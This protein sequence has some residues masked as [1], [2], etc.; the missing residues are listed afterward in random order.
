ML[1]GERV[2]VGCDTL[3]LVLLLLPPLQ[4]VRPLMIKTLTTSEDTPLKN[5]W[6]GRVE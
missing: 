1:E 6:M 2:N 5:G 4:E 3:L